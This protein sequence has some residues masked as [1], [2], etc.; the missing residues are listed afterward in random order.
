MS[1]S[2]SSHQSK[3]N[4]HCRL[5]HYALNPH[6]RLWFGVNWTLPSSGVP[7]THSLSWWF[8][9]PKTNQSNLNQSDTIQ[10]A[11][12]GL[13]ERDLATVE[14]MTTALHAWHT[15]LDCGLIRY[16]WRWLCPGPRHSLSLCSLSLPPL[17]PFYIWLFDWSFRMFWKID[18]ESVE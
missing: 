14:S 10:C 3:T 18:N 16:N 2:P 7:C 11:G 12:D 17:F 9:R 6:L 5:S 15:P 1:I 8:T 13:N 4:M